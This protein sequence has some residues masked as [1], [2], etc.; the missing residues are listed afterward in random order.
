M[1]EARRRAVRERRQRR[2]GALDARRPHRAGPGDRVRALELPARGRRALPRRCR[3]AAQRHARPPRPARLVRS[4]TRPPSCACSSASASATPPCC[5]ST[6]PTSPRWTTPTCP[7]TAA[8]CASRAT[9]LEPFEEAFAAS[10]LRGPAQP[11]QRGL[12]DR[13]RARARAPTRPAQ[14]PRCATSRRPPHRLEQVRELRGV[15]Y[16]NDSK[17]TN[18]E[19][20]LQALAS[21]DAPL[22]V[23]LGGSLKGADFAPLAA[24]LAQRRQR[25]L[26]DRRGRARAAPGAHRPRA[27]SSVDCGT[28][29]RAVRIAA[30]VAGDGRRRAA[31]ARPAP[32]TTS[33]A[34][35]RSAASASARSS[36]RSREPLARPRRA[37]P[38]SC[39]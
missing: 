21:F 2:H 8:G 4:P 39:S 33:S 25:R 9:E 36:R 19:A 26:P 34:T 3:R 13:R 12:R 27:S 7:A 29:E 6:T 10:R 31:L 38:S 37:A 18:V 30:S 11:R 24:P 17:A 32:R 20:T 14:L 23:I 28:L 22:H 1:L 35:T 16:V 5:A 15:R